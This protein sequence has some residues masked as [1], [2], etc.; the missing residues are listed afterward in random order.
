MLRLAF[1]WLTENSET[2]TAPIIYD[3]GF[4][5]SQVRAKR[6]SANCLK[7]KPGGMCVQRFSRCHHRVLNNIKN[8]DRRTKSSGFFFFL[9]SFLVFFPLCSSSLYP[10]MTFLHR[11]PL[12]FDLHSYFTFR[13]YYSID[14]AI[15]G[16]VFLGFFFKHTLSKLLRVLC[17]KSDIKSD[18]ISDLLNLNKKINSIGV[19]LSH[20]RLIFTF[21]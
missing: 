19:Y 21:L 7:V 17:A 2:F 14:H 1:T 16:G 13:R 10:V 9:F 20:S 4:A 3:D 11:S 6:Y 8:A 12:T 18:A 5:S 15:G